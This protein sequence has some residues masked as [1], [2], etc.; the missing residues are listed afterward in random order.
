MRTHLGNMKKQVIYRVDVDY[1]Y[2]SIRRLR[3]PIDYYI[4]D[5]LGIISDSIPNIKK[6]SVH[7]HFVNILKIRIFEC[8]M[9]GHIEFISKQ[10][11]YVSEYK[12]CYY[13]LV[14]NVKEYIRR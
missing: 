5:V 3:K 9:L 4:Q 14:V 6:F 2:K 1:N 11:R 7:R 8:P 13:A 12:I 10:F